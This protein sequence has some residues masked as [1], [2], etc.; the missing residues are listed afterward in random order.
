MQG[1]GDRWELRIYMGN[2]TPA[3]TE[4]AMEKYCNWLR[5]RL[6]DFCEDHGQQALRQC[7]GEIDF[8]N[9]GL[10][11]QEVWNL[12]E[13]LAQYQVHAAVLKLYKNRIS[14]GGVLA[15][16]EF[17]RSNRRAGP[18]HEMHLSHNEIDDDSAQELFLTLRS[19]R[20]RYPPRRCVD[21]ADRGAQT[22][23]WIRLNQNRI[24]DAAKL[25]KDLQAD[26]ISI[27]PARSTQGCGPTRCCRS[28]CP[29]L[30]LYLF[31]DQSQQVQRRES[32][33]ADDS[34][35]G[36]GDLGEPRQP[37]RRDECSSSGDQRDRGDSD[38]R[39]RDRDHD[40]RGG[41]GDA[42]E[43]EHPGEDSH[44]DERHGDEPPS[45]DDDDDEPGDEPG[46]EPSGE[47]RPGEEAARAQK[48]R[49]AGKRA[50]RG[51]RLP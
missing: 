40:R 45:D 33:T 1:Q 7:C 31:N 24:K 8:S 16:C 15:M 3:L 19:L 9:N 51:R 41:S 26:G 21:G 5:N 35:R 23:V 42:G 29:L 47:G 13:A 17:L 28:D 25:V 18:V 32:S 43:E 38:R 10:G 30:H 50:G 22:P 37:R 11:N 2:I 14:Q 46:A 49:A 4:A 34:K 39:R 44:R 48:G 27:C 36:S 6:S 12:L 20:P